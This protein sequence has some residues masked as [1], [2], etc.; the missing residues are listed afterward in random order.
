M[1]GRV[2]MTKII[3]QMIRVALEMRA[4][5][6]LTNG[7]GYLMASIATKCLASETDDDEE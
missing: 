5:R 7:G 2:A 6:D 1:H 3:A 4:K